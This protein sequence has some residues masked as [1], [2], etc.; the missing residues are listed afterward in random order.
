MVVGACLLVVTRT[1]PR[2]TDSRFSFRFPLELGHGVVVDLEIEGQGG[3]NPE[4][5]QGIL[6]ELLPGNPDEL[7]TLARDPDRRKTLIGQALA[8]ADDE[9]GVKNLWA[10]L[11]WGDSGGTSARNALFGRP[12]S[13]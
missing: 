6:E 8:W 5:V 13:A 1:A 7:L 9:G 4:R 2:A 11:A 3:T 10:A 12:L